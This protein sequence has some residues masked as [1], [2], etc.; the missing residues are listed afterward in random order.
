M[1]G[2]LDR[3]Q[4]ALADRYAIV[5]PGRRRVPGRAVARR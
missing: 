5:T 1:A 3:L 2:P 4:A